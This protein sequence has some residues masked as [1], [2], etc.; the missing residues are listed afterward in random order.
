MYLHYLVSS[1]PYLYSASAYSVQH[2]WLS[3]TGYSA[4]ACYPFMPGYAS[5]RWSNDY[6]NCPDHAHCAFNEQVPVY[7]ES[8]SAG[9]RSRACCSSESLHPS[10][11]LDS[12]PV[13]KATEVDARGAQI[14]AD[15]SWKNWDPTEEPIRLLGSVFDATPSANGSTIGPSSAMA[16]RLLW[17]RLLVTYGCF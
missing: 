6:L 4:Q 12:G 3:P 7:T 10:A 8:E 1:S 9:L 16:P 13:P 2:A 11:P 15:Y 14:P 5:P 17:W